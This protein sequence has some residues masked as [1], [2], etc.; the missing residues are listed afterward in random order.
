MIYKYLYKIEYIGN[1]DIPFKYYIGSRKSKILPE[2]DLLKTY[3]T[4]SKI[5]KNI[6]K[7]DGI[8]VFKIL[9]IKLFNENTNI[10]HEE[11]KWLDEVSAKDNP[12]YFNQSNINGYLEKDKVNIICPHCNTKNYG[13]PFEKCSNCDKVMIKYICHKCNKSLNH[14]CETC[15]SCGYTAF[16]DYKYSCKM[17]GHQLSNPSERCPN[18]KYRIMDDVKYECKNCGKIINHPNETCTDCGYCALKHLNYFCKECGTI[19]DNPAKKC[20]ECGYSPMINCNTECQKCG[21]KL[22]YYI[23]RCSNCGYSAADDFNYTCPKCGKSLSSSLEHCPSCGFFSRDNFKFTCKKCG[24]SIPNST[25]RC[26]ACNYSALD[27]ANFLCEKC[28]NPISNPMARCKKCHY[29]RRDHANFQCKN[30]GEPGLK[31]S[32][33]R[34]SKCGI[35]KA[36]CDSWKKSN[37]S[38]DLIFKGNIIFSGFK[39]NCIYYLKDNQISDKKTLAKSNFFDGAPFKPK[40]KTTKYY[41]QFKYD[42]LI[43]VKKDD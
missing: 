41:N 17:C 43:A 13:N 5:I 35:I 31:N 16:N 28:S 42:G 6:I 10:L 29:S 36:G 18:C 32:S 34:C 22:N 3:F 33:S 12:L 2:E 38:F 15:K 25:S 23:E 1:R 11:S 24:E 9:E 30:C 39:E 40:S 4:S 19:K 37:P 14:A 26:K 8:N 21:T 7:E 20:T 27:D